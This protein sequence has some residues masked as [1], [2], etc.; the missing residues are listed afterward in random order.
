[1][2]TNAKVVA[3]PAIA[4]AL[5]PSV[6]VILESLN[7][8]DP[9]VTYMTVTAALL[10]VD[11]LLLLSANDL[12]VLFADIKSKKVAC[13]LAN[14][15]RIRALIHYLQRLSDDGALTSPLP[16]IDDSVLRLERKIIDSEDVK[17][18]KPKIDPPPKLTDP[19]NWMKFREVLKNYL[20]CLFNR[21]DVP[22]YYV[23]R[24]DPLHP[25]L[26]RPSSLSL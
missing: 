7:I 22:L 11:D 4:I 17:A 26:P 23:L 21:A 16:P 5:V 9:L 10:S 2:A 1:M 18:D 15:A 24:Q 6:Q 25:T 3:P 12:E 13:S 14:G 8:P 20:L 19:K